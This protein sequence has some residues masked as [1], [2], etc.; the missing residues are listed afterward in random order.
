M[1]MKEKK[2]D[3]DVNVALPYG[4]KYAPQR[5]SADAAGDDL[6][7]RKIEYLSPTKVKIHLGVHFEFSSD[8]EVLLLPRSNSGK[9][10]WIL[11]NCV[12][13]GDPDYRG[14]Y[15]A[16]FDY[17]GPYEEIQYEDGNV[18]A[19]IEQFPYEEGNRVVQC[20]FQRNYKPKYNIVSLDDMTKTERGSGGHGSTGLD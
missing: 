18:R 7:A 10:S 9:S 6:R 19:E 11:S 4:Q 8:W 1:E 3:L 12:G 14:E 2:F 5:G 17:T 16:I 20:I 15:L 13:L